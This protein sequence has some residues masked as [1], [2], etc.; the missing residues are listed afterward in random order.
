[1]SDDAYPDLTGLDGTDVMVEAPALH[2]SEP[3]FASEVAGL[4]F[5]AYGQVDELTGERV[6]PQPGDRLHLVREPANPHDRNAIQV[7]WRNAHMLGHL[8]RYTAE[9]IAPLMD[10][11]AA[12]RAYVHHPGDGEAWSLRALVVGPAAEEI[13]GRYIQHLADAALGR[14]EEEREHRLMLRDR[15]DLTRKSMERHRRNRVRDAVETLRHVPCEPIL[16]QP[17]AAGRTDVDD[18]ADVLRCSRSTVVRIAAS[19]CITLGRWDFTVE[20]TPEF[21][22]ALLEWDRRPRR[23][24]KPPKLKG[25]IGLRSFPAEP[26]TGGFYAWPH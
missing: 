10:A 12:A 23:G 21:R 18:I 9:R 24:T 20:V 4:Q 3:W 16:P 13:H 7:W 25:K 6:I 5:Y 22:A 26:D 17:N 15:A 14:S 19:V 1:M 11:G 2:A 8:P